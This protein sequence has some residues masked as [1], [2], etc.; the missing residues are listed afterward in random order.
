MVLGLTMGFHRVSL[1]VKSV[2]SQ[3]D[4]VRYSGNEKKNKVRSSCLET[5]GYWS[6]VVGELF[7]EPFLREQMNKS[8]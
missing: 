1:T 6:H 4:P 8:K 5:P 2:Y 7:L 3:P